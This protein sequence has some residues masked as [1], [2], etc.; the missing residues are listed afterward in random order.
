MAA[1]EISL[2]GGVFVGR[3]GHLVGACACEIQTTSSRSVRCSSP[4]Q[5]TGGRVVD[6]LMEVGRAEEGYRYDKP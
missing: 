1:V 5:F 2:G 3:E 4:A 6:M